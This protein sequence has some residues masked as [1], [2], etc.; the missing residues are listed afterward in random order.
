MPSSIREIV[1]TIFGKLSSLWDERVFDVGSAVEGYLKS[2]EVEDVVEGILKGICPH[3]E[4]V[5]KRIDDLTKLELLVGHKGLKIRIGQHK[6][7]SYRQ[8]NPSKHY[9]YV[10]MP[11]NTAN[12]IPLVIFSEE[13][14]M[15]LVVCAE[16]VMAS[17]LE[18][19]LRPQYFAAH[20][21]GTPT[22]C[23][24]QGWTEQVGSIV[25]NG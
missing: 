4:E 2:V 22:S 15:P 12:F 13:V 19:F 21:S 7:A 9:E 11:G 16:A 8:K 10:D 23:Q 6:R 18:N 14:P 1:G 24:L 5:I 25:N 17:I 3:M 20:Y